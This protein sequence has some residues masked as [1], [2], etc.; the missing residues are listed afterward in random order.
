MGVDAL[1]ARARTRRLVLMR[2]TVTVT[3]VTGRV[4][5]DASGDYD[6]TVATV[7]TG[8][9]DVRPLV[10][11]AQEVQ[12]GERELALRTFDVVL[13]WTDT[14]TFERG[15]LV[16]VDVSDDESLAGRVLTVRAVGHGGRRTGHH[17][18]AEDR[19]A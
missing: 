13:P 18:D 14:V 12:A 6:P 8:P 1:L 2:D 9:A 17:L 11:A 5:N 15:D 19:T 10:M 7:Y 3:R 4:W 16:E